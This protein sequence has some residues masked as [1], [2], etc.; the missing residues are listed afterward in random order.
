MLSAIRGNLSSNTTVIELSKEFNN[1]SQQKLGKDL[2]EIS[3]SERDYLRMEATSLVTN[4]KSDLVI[5]DTHYVDKGSG[6]F[7]I[8]VPSEL[9]SSVDFWMLVES[10]PEEILARRLR[11]QKVKIRDCSL[12]SIVKEAKR[13]RMVAEHLSINTKKP[14]YIIRNDNFLVALHKIFILINNFVRNSN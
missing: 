12:D 4:L 7:K 8:L 5:V 3:K 6:K 9:M 14:L 10:K 1:L 2:N 13:E 11:D